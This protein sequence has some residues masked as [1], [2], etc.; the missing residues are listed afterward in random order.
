MVAFFL[1]NMLLQPTD[2]WL[3]PSS[4]EGE[5]VNEDK[6]AMNSQVTKNIVGA[7]STYK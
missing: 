5:A 1:S 7:F 6:L 3:P 4:P 2:I